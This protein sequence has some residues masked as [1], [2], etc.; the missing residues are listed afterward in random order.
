MKMTRFK[1]MLSLIL[2][3]VIVAAMTLFASGCSDKNSTAGE[4]SQITSSAE[5]TTVLGT[6]QTKFTFTVVGLDGKEAKFEINTDKTIVSDALLE[7]NLIAGEDSQYGLYVKTVNGVTVDYDKD[8]KYWAFY[9]NGAYGQKGVSETEVK[10]G[11]TYT[12]KAE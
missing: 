6:G 5:Q 4:S 12:F 2:C 10:A 3:I 11:E 9:V 8:G 1:K 7:H